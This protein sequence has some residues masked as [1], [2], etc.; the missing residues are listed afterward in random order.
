MTLKKNREILK[1][2]QIFKKFKELK[3]F[4]YMKNFLAFEKSS[5][6]RK[7]L[8]FLK[9]IKDGKKKNKI[10]TKQIENRPEKTQCKTQRK[11]AQKNEPSRFCFPKP[12]RGRLLCCLGHLQECY[13][14]IGFALS[15]K[16]TLFDASTT[17]YHSVLRLHVRPAT[18]ELTSNSF[19]YEG[20]TSNSWMTPPGVKYLIRR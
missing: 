5:R 15:T 3:L 13:E 17:I 14:G 1:S 20:F 11:S 4:W 12:V 8:M 19:F 18:P 6:I 7:N 9:G 16:R 10:K 2:S